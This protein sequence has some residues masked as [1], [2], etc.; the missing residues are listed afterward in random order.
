MVFFVSDDFLALLFLFIIFNEEVFIELT[1]Y[2]ERHEVLYDIKHCCI[3][4]DDKVADHGNKIA[5]ESL[6]K[7]RQE[8][9]A[10]SGELPLMIDS[11]FHL[12]HTVTDLFRHFCVHGEASDEPGQAESNCWHLNLDTLLKLIEH[13]VLEDKQAD[14]HL[15]DE[16]SNGLDHHVKHVLLQSE[17]KHLHFVIVFVDVFFK[18][19]F[20]LYFLLARFLIIRDF[21]TLYRFYC[22]IQELML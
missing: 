9:I 8:C 16:D 3:K 20:F 11:V 19:L 10:P 14:A 17:T 7:A 2:F 5:N 1:D 12:V 15:E 4:D 22:F 21:C 6:S 13:G 18:F